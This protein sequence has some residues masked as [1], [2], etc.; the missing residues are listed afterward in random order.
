[1]KPYPQIL[2]FVLLVL[3]V[4]FIGRGEIVSAQESQA[5]QVELLTMNGSKANLSATGE[6]ITS[7]KI[8]DLYSRGA[9]QID[10]VKQAGARF[11]IEL[12]E[13]GYQ[14]CT[15]SRI[16]APKAR[17]YGSQGQARSEAER[18]VPGLHH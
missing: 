18:V 4:V 6:G 2:C 10:L 9:T 5:P 11:K 3:L 1:M 12:P 13:R 8:G 15:K 17:K 14:L 16:G 7:Y